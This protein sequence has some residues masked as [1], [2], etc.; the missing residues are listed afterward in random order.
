MSI[1]RCLFFTLIAVHL[2]AS[3]PLNTEEIERELA[4]AKRE[5][6][7]AK[8]SFQP[9]Y[10]G[11][12]LTGSA[13]IVP[14]GKVNVQPYLFVTTNY[15][16]YTNERHT[17]TIKDLV[18]V[19]PT[20]IM[21]TGIF[22]GSDVVLTIAGVYQWQNGVSSGG[23]S[24]T[25]VQWGLQLLPEDL[26]TPEIKLYINQ[27][28]PT[29]KFERGSLRKNGLDL[30]GN[31]SFITSLSFN[32]SKVIWWLFQ[33]PIN[34]R[35]TCAFDVYTSPVNVEGL[36]AYGGAPDTQGTVT[37]GH[38]LKINLGYQGSINRA[39][40]VVCDAVYTYTD[41][42]LFAG[43]S[44]TTDAGETAENGS[45]SKDSLSL[46]PGIEY[47]LDSNSGIVFGLWFSVY[48]RNEPAFLSGIFT[49]QI[50]F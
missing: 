10:S 46:A 1:A 5:F 45:P 30:I 3:S 22:P 40:G 19:N 11:P 16:N 43:F 15:A 6:E 32:S 49:Y 35:L 41:P 2:C 39:W 44:G 47:N 28:F 7:E 24:D 9:W 12:L 38:E 25:T 42:S 33:N 23:Y 13:S 26:Y 34:L 20:A 50:T 48:G 37:R 17:K 31:G 4:I 29:G 36:H 18:V 27:S 14:I 8:E 21:Q